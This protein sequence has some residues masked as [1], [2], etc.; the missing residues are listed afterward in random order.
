[1]KIFLRYGF[2]NLEFSINYKRD[3][4]KW[5]IENCSLNFLEVLYCVYLVSLDKDWVIELLCNG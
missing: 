4:F 3:F 1:M 5:K 2:W